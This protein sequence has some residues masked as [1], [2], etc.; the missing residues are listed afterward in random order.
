MKVQRLMLKH[1]YVCVY[2]TYVTYV[3]FSKIYLVTSLTSLT[4]VGNI[5][6]GTCF[7]TE[8]LNIF[9]LF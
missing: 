8:Q 6:K 3:C 9:I 1:M 4:Q 5:I 2:A 7:S